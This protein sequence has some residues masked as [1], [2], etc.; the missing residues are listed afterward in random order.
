MMQ[1]VVLAC[2]LYLHRRNAEFAVKVEKA[3]PA[4]T[5]MPFDD[6]LFS[7]LGHSIPADVTPIVGDEIRTGTIAVVVFCEIRCAIFRVPQH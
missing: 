2:L 4:Y 3:M 7:L 5:L 6:E 1:Q